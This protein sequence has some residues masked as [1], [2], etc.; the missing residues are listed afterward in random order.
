MSLHCTILGWVIKNTSL[1]HQ[2]LWIS[3][4]SV[5]NFHIKWL[6][7]DERGKWKITSHAHHF[8]RKWLTVMTV[9]SDLLCKYE[10]IL[11]HPM[12]YWINRYT[13]QFSFW[14]HHLSIQSCLYKNICICLYSYQLLSLITVM[15]KGSWKTLGIDDR[16]KFI[17]KNLGIFLFFYIL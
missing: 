7:N 14:F 13:F 5:I 3:L 9:G 2:L 11:L 1:G 17:F 16:G 12:L 6:W 10:S 4:P 15:S 8:L